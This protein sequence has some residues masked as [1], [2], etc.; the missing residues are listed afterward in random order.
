MMTDSVENKMLSVLLKGPIASTLLK[1]AAPNIAGFLVLSAVTMAEMWYVG[2]LG[3]SALAGLALAFPMVMLMQMLSAGSIGGVIAAT[4]AR[5]IG[6]G[7][8]EEANH[9][10][11]HAVGIAVLASAVFSV[12]FLSFGPA[13]YRVIG[14]TDD[15]IRHAVAYSDAIFVGVLAIWLFNIFAS[16]IR[17]AGDMKTPARAMIV[18]AAIQVFTG[19]VLSQGWLGFPSLGIAGI[20][21]SQVIANSIG[22]LVI[23][24]RLFRGVNGISFERKYL[25]FHRKVV[26]DL[27]RIG[28]VATLNPFLS[29]A[30]VV[31]LTALVSRFG[32]ASLAGFGIGAR[33]EFILVPIVFGLGAAMISMVGSNV[34]AG[35]VRRAEKIGWI[36]GGMAALVCGSIGAFVGFVPNSWAGLFTDDPAVFEAAS[37]YLIIVGPSYLFFGLGLSLYF[38]SQGAHAVVWPVMASVGRLVVAVGIGGW[39]LSFNQDYRLLLFCV[40]GSLAAYGFGAALPLFLGAWQRANRHLSVGKAR[41]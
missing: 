27:S 34:G 41:S 4:T 39:V 15:N 35:Q 26:S 10:V 32:E 28:I 1:M 3:T 12:L 33:L 7:R 30:S 31:L 9:I 23:W 29:I 16:L 6:G 17:G 5:A 19:G 22:A 14:G 11:W 20:G 38:A 37:D 2:R 18:V 13:I 25:S 24:G 40:A 8:L 21:W 36:G